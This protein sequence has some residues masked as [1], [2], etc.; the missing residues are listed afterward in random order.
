MK[1]D[2]R[3]KPS[4]GWKAIL[5]PKDCAA[6]GLAAVE[7]RIK[8]VLGQSPEK[9][10]PEEEVVSMTPKETRKRVLDFIGEMPVFK[11][12]PRLREA[13]EK[14]FQISPEIRVSFKDADTIR[15]DCAKKRI[16]IDPSLPVTQEDCRQLDPDN[17]LL[18]TEK[19]ITVND[20]KQFGSIDAS[21]W[22]WL[23]VKQYPSIGPR[24]V[25]KRKDN[26]LQFLKGVSLLDA[27]E[28]KKEGIAFK[29]LFLKKTCGWKHEDFLKFLTV[30]KSV[31]V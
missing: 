22:E 9:T 21:W 4:A 7:S 23:K 28:F 5:W 12:N 26:T 3:N 30:F 29:A 17:P 18:E 6:R 19:S 11:E 10:E 16:E 20:L 13:L 27:L 31:L 1:S 15:I 25:L 2:I 8:Q 14:H 24:I